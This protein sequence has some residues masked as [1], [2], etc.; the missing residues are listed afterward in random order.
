MISQKT[1]T[2]FKDVAKSGKY[3]T[4]AIA[5]EMITRYQEQEPDGLRSFMYGRHMFDTL[6]QAPQCAGIRIFNALNDRMDQTLIFTAADAA[7]EHIT[8]CALS[9]GSG[10]VSYGDPIWGGGLFCPYDCPKGGEGLE[11]YIRDMRYRKTADLSS[12]GEL[13]LRSTAQEMIQAYQASEPEGVYSI[14]FGREVF[15][16]ILN[17]PGCAGIRV[18]NGINDAGLHSFIVVAINAK[19]GNILKYPT[20]TETVAFMVNAPLAGGTTYCPFDCPE[21][22]EWPWK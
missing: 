11:I 4:T 10:P 5:Q 12:A 1:N 8:N 21:P 13:M 7:G 14:L 19:G 2:R 15:E 16:A 6:L 3:F 17:V 18:F 20:A 22:W 9:T